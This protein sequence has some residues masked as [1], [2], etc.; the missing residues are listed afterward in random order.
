[1][2]L[3]AVNKEL[4]L[5]LSIF[6]LAYLL[7]RLVNAN[8]MLL[9]FYSLPAIFSAYFFGRRHAT[10]TAFASILLVGILTYF[11]PVL[12][13]E[14]QKPSIYAKRWYDITVWRGIL[15]ITAYAM[16]TLYDRNHRRILELQRAYR[17]VLH[18]LRQFVAQ[19]K[20][21]E[22]HSYR[23]SVYAAKIAFYMGFGSRRVEDVR[24]AAM[25]HDIG[26]LEISRNL[27]YKA[28]RLT[29]EEFDKVKKH[30]ENS[31]DIMGGVRRDPCEDNPHYPRPP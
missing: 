20:Y 26:K 2:R 21:T 27:L 1:M 30:A 17:G 19:D 15:I 14:I 28:A 10:L 12:F 16:G 6:S 18:I 29:R 11:N 9:G 31:T 8:Y 3:A 25:L 4:W 13:T 24:A 7:N 23:V 5:L 22:N